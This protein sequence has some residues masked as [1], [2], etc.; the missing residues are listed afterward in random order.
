LSQS[1]CLAIPGVQAQQ[2]TAIEVDDTFNGRE[3][4]LQ[5]G[6]TLKVSLSDNASTGYRWSIPPELKAN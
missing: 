5:P 2:K 6:Q 3:G 1:G 4:V